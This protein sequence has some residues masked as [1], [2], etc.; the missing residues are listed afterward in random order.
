[1]YIDMYI[2]EECT[3]FVSKSCIYV[4]KGPE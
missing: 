1:M 4:Q 3:I 2:H